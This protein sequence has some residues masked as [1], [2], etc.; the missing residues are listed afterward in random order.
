MFSAPCQH[1]DHLPSVAHK[2]WKSW[3]YALA[4]TPGWRY[5]LRLCSELTLP[6]AGRTGNAQ[7]KGWCMNIEKEGWEQ[8]LFSIDRRRPQVSNVDRGGFF[9][10]GCLLRGTKKSSFPVLHLDYLVQGEH[11]LLVTLPPNRGGKI[12]SAGSSCWLLVLYKTLEWLLL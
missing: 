8:T 5:R 10:V 11:Q 6:L 12:R 4:D 9:R 3:R 7:S 2:Y 1:R